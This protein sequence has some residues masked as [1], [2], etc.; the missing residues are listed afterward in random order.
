MKLIAMIYLFEDFEFDISRMELRRRGSVIPIEPQVFSLLE[1]LITQHNRFV[2]KDE[3]NEIV[4][5]GR[6]VS[7]SA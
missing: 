1:L 2:S 4:W 7:D 5:G 6:S 3:I